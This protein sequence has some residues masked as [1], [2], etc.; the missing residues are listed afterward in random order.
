MA[1]WYMHICDVCRLLNGDTSLK[2]CF[3]CPL[4]DSWICEADANDWGRRAQA[5]AVA[6][7]KRLFS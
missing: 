5:A 2:V 7:V 3:Y 6:Q 4:C 1:G